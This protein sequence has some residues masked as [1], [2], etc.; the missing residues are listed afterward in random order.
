MSAL[1]WSDAESALTELAAVFFR[2][3]GEA[4]GHDQIANSDAKYRTL[5]EQLPAVVFM[6]YLDRGIG[7]AYV[8]P[9][10]EEMLGFSQAEWLEDPVRWYHQIHPEDQQRW[11]IEAADMFLTGR[12]LQSAYRVLA[13]DG[14]VVWFQCEAKMVRRDDG[15]PWFIH[16]LAFDITELKR[17]EQTLQEERNVV[18]AILDTVGALVVVLGP[19]GRIVR[20][21][22]ACERISGYSANAMRGRL[23]GELFSIPGDLIER[24]DFESDLVTADSGRRRIAWSTTVLPGTLATPAC[25]I[26]TGIDITERKR[27][28]EAILEVSAGVQRQIG[29]DMHDGLGQHLTGIAFMSKVLEQKLADT[30]QPEAATAAAIVRLVNEAI[31]TTRELSRGLLPVVSEAHGLMSALKHWAAEVEHLYHIP[32][33]VRGREPLEITEVR[34]ATHLYHIAQEAVNNAIRHAHPTHLLVSLTDEPGFGVLTVEDDGGGLP[35][36]L[37]GHGG[38]GLQIMTYR[39]NMIGGSLTVERRKAGGTTVCCRFPTT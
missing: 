14:R 9:R 4:D 37:P 32:C 7:E 5:I 17:T 11:S 31:H 27:T 21:N 22:R 30:H 38:L 10:I 3:P 33:E 12:S 19:E 18:S 15:R 8:N 1:S 13:R 23:F 36:A 20:S 39:S 16:G 6:A 35:T 25:V 29:Q 24:R 34:T 2:A 26:A 28:E